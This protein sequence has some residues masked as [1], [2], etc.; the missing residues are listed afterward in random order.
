MMGLAARGAGA[1]TRY[2]AV[3]AAATLAAVLLT[4]LEFKHEPVA[5][6]TAKRDLHFGGEIVA[7]TFEPATGTATGMFQWWVEA[8]HGAAVSLRLTAKYVVQ[9]AGLVGQDEDAAKAFVAKV[10]RFASYPYFRALA[11]QI[12]WEAGANLPPM[13]VL[14][15]SSPLPA[16]APAPTETKKET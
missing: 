16:P 14:R 3:V 8:R 5:D 11:S 12:N 2:N 6:T 1:A 9:Y 4:E 15:E 10:G 7:V 13:P